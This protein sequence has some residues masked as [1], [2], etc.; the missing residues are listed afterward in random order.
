[1]QTAKSLSI[2]FIARKTKADDS[3]AEIFVRIIVDGDKP[4][5]ISLKRKIKHHEWSNKSEVVKGKTYEAN[6]INDYIEDVRARIRVKYRELE[7]N[8]QLITAQT[9]KDA[10][11]GVQATLKEHTLSELM[12][13]YKTIWEPKLKNGGFKNYKTTI[14]YI[15]RFLDSKVPGTDV[16][17]SQVNGEF[18]TNFEHYIRTTPIKAHDPCIGNGVGKHVQRLKRILNWAKEDLKWIQQSQV[19]DYKCPLKR[20][21]RIKLRFEEILAIERQIFIEPNVIYIM[22][23]FLFS[24]YTGLAFADVMAMNETDLEDDLNGSTWLHIYR[25]K[26]N[27]PCGVPLL[28]SAKRILQKYRD[29]AQKLGRSTIFR[30]VTNKTANDILKMITA[31]AGIKSVITFHIA[32]HTFAK[33]VAL[34]NGIPLETVQIMLGHT[35]ITTTQI[36]A[37][38]D[39]EK[40]I[41]DMSGLEERLEQKRKLIGLAMH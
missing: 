14:S 29:E 40:V 19:K 28:K 10:Y 41:T 32:R 22:E 30:R 2:N 8:E 15:E 12:K 24:C 6:A 11:L 25:T 4:K 16:R 37:D 35:K 1:M 3:I 31:E 36:Y 9:V 17:L 13:Y 21:K 7:R 27:E 5:E 26:S 39:E 38:V 23:L 18:A 34:K 33:T 20:S